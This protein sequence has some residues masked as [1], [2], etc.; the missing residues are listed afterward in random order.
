MID[1]IPNQ[2]MELMYILAVYLLLKFSDNIQTS[3]TPPS[4]IVI[5]YN[6]PHP[7]PLLVILCHTLPPPPQTCMA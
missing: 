4:V 5:Y 3:L 2:L 6:W 1:K 7:H